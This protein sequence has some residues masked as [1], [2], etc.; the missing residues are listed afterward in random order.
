[1]LTETTRVRGSICRREWKLM[2]VPHVANAKAAPTRDFASTIALMFRYFGNMVRN[3]T[4]ALR[5][6]A[7]RRLVS[8][9]GVTDQRISP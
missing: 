4:R 1:M 8:V 9:A 6:T 3:N 7:V 5:L 2:Y